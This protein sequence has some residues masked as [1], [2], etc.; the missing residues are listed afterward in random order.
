MDDD[1]VPIAREAQQGGEL[2]T[3]DILGSAAENSVTRPTPTMARA[4]A[5]S[6]ESMRRVRSSK[7]R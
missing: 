1:R 7:A 3:R 5:N 2:G 6:I 4:N